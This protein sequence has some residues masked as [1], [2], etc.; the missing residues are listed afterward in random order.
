MDKREFLEKLAL[1]LAG[2]VPRSVI[3]EN[4]SYYDSY[5]SGEMRKGRSQ[6]DVLNE[7]GDPRLIA[8]T[9][10]EANGGG[11]DMAGVYEDSDSGENTGYE[12]ETPDYQEPPHTS[13]HHIQI[14]GFWFT[15]IA[16]IVLLFV[17][18][19]VGTVIGGIFILLGPILMPVLL[20]CLVLWMFKGPR[21]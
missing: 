1:A 6:A 16:V 18:W 5:I 8:R 13:F 2:Q 20:I 11:N 10:I 4:I 19:L 3:E 12:Q 15:L 7:L 17:I 21:R 14:G 9:I